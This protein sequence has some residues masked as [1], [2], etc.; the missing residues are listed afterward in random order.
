MNFRV[1]YAT[2]SMRVYVLSS[3]SGTAFLKYSL[4]SFKKHITMACVSEFP[5]ELLY[6]E[7]SCSAIR[8]MVIKN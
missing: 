1:V 3:D 7:V 8:F 5:Y 4:R 6:F 2:L